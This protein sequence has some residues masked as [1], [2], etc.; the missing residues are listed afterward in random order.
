MMS[1]VFLP[2]RSSEA[3]SFPKLLVSF[4]SLGSGKRKKI[5]PWRV[6][7]GPGH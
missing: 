3:M 6:E 1:A 2:L 5:H 4:R 7:V